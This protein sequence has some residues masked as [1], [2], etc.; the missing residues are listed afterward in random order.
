MLKE[1]AQRGLAAH[2][3]QGTPT[4]RVGPTEV[5]FDS[6]LIAGSALMPMSSACLF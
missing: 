4:D 2:P 1:K 3:S 6:P 5:G